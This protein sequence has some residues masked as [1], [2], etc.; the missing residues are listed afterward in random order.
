MKMTSNKNLNYKIVDLVESY[1]FHKK[2]TSIRVQA[3][4]LHFFNIN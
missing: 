3:K 2:L 1:N 4:K